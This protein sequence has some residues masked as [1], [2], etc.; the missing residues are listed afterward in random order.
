[1]GQDFLGLAI[2]KEPNDLIGI[3]LCIHKWGVVGQVD[4]PFPDG[5][6]RGRATA[7]Q[8]CAGNRHCGRLAWLLAPGPGALVGFVGRREMG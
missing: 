3:Y 7:E 2:P 4:L 5:L 8:P 1:M 6:H